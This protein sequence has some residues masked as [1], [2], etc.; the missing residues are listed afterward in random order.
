MVGY[1]RNVALP[2]LNVLD[3]AGRQV[4]HAQFPPNGGAADIG[5]VPLHFNPR[6]EGYRHM[7]IF[8]MMVFYNQNFEIV[9]QDDLPERINKFRRF[10]AEY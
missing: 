5:D 10:L 6:I 8:R 9:P 1:G 2:L 7:E 4:F 3:A